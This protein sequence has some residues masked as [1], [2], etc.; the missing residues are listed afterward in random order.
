MLLRSFLVVCLVAAQ[1]CAPTEPGPTAHADEA[2]VL[3]CVR[4]GGLYTSCSCGC[5]PI[6][7]RT[8]TIKTNGQILERGAL[9]ESVEDVEETPEE[10]DP[11]PE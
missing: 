4:K 11:D 2:C 10:T 9:S 6:C 8:A 7:E 5:D 3:A 1:G